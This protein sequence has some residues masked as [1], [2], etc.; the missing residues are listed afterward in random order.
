MTAAS[1]PPLPAVIGGKYRP[2]RLIARGG[3]GAVYEVVHANTGEHLAL[4]LML[5][6]SLLAPELVAR[7]RREARIQSSVKGDHVVR[8]VDADVAPE[9]DGAPFLVMELL[10]GHDLERICNQR[11]PAWHEITDW[12]G[13]VGPALDR[14]HQRGIVH[15]DLKPENLFLAE[16]EAL[17]PIVKI[18]DFGVAKLI[19]DVDQSS[20]LTGQILGTPRYMAPEQ[21]AG[22]K[23]ISPAADR[24][25]LGLIAFRFLSGR[26]YF[27]GGENW[28][29]LLQA[30]TRG[31]TAPPSAMGC[32][33]GA[34]FDAWFARAC[35]VDPTRRFASCAEQ[36]DALAGTLAGTSVP[37]PVPARRRQWSA[38]RVL[39]LAVLTG[40]CAILTVLWTV[41]RGASHRS[42]AGSGPVAAAASPAAP[43]AI[44]APGSRQLSAAIA[45]RDPPVPSVAARPDAGTPARARTGAIVGADLPGPRRRRVRTATTIDGPPAP[46]ATSTKD[47]IWEEP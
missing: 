40:I 17:P 47:R 43:A 13:Q 11:R 5:A 16:R 27:E 31:P 28:V 42:P 19:T 23:N 24:F 14:A 38:G 33:L 1:P 34:A 4:K 37:V 20:T 6:R 8:V 2:L 9:I 22:A 29:T 21:A 3:M 15:R 30:V 44:A 39:G 18:L 36:V 46:T 10:V 41:G 35:A 32:D 25:A 7:F 26:H 12:L 45:P